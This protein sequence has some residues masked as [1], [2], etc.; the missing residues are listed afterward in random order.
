MIAVTVDGE[1]WKFVDRAQA[2]KMTGGTH[3]RYRNYELEERL[4]AEYDGQWVISE[5]C[6]FDG[7]FCKLADFVPRPHPPMVDEPP[8]P[9]DTD[10]PWN[11][12]DP[13]KVIN[14]RVAAR[15][16]ARRDSDV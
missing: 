1:E 5:W 14:Y 8:R 2:I 9:P 10:V 11:E 4:E 3:D 6:P 16:A 13:A 12:F 7:R 15:D